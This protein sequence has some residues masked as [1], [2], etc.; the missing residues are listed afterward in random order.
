MMAGSP[1]TPRTDILADSAAASTAAPRYLDAA[2]GLSTELTSVTAHSAS[3]VLAQ[4]I[5]GFRMRGVEQNLS[6]STCSSSG[7]GGDAA[8]PASF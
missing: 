5:P 2:V 8:D 4:V 3:D 7:V 1:K 6:V